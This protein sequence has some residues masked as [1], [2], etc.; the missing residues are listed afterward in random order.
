MLRLVAEKRKMQTPV[1]LRI[2]WEQGEKGTHLDEE[3]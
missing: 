1:L 3:F 2:E